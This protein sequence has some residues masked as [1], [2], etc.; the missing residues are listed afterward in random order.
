MLFFVFLSLG[1]SVESFSCDEKGDSVIGE[2]VS[3]ADQASEIA[4]RNYLFYS[5]GEQVLKPALVGISHD[6]EGFAKSGNRVWEV[7]IVN[8]EKGLRAMYF[9]NPRTG[10]AYMVC[11]PG[12]WQENRCTNP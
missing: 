3:S 2:K 4:L 5:F 9:I 8:K 11:K 1:Y 12:Q 10:A 6:I 7:R